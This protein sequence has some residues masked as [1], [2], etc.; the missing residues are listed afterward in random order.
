MSE[1]Y[2][3]AR[4]AIPQHKV[5]HSNTHGGVT[6]ARSGSWKARLE[7]WEIS[8]CET[9]LADRLVANGYELSG[10]PK[11]RRAHVRRARRRRPNVAGRAGARRS[12][13]A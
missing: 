1:P 3:V 12:V 5:W 2:H 10:A 7:P 8:V 6:T 11:A 9:V 4:V 13:T